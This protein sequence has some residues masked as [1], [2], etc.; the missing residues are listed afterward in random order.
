MRPTLWAYM[1]ARTMYIFFAPNAVEN[2]RGWPPRYARDIVHLVVKVQSKC[3]DYK[4][5]RV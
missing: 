5:K 3:T 2:V 1:Y 4:Y